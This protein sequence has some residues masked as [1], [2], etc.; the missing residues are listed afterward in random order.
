MLLV[1]ILISKRNQSMNKHKHLVCFKLFQM[2]FI[3]SKLLELFVQILASSILCFL[4]VLFKSHFEIGIKDG[5]QHVHHEEQAQHE[6]DDEVKAVPS[7]GL[8]GWEHD[9]REVRCCH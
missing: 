4:N 6:V 2:P 3:A 7:V 9:I 8:I 1:D 5:Q